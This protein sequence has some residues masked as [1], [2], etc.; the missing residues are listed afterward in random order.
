MKQM[1]V[2]LMVLA[3]LVGCATAPVSSETAAAVPSDRLFNA[4]LTTSAPDKAR[5]VVTR[6][7][8][9]MGSACTIQVFCDGTLA[10]GIR[11]EEKI[12]L[13]LSPGEHIVGV[14]HGGGICGGG[15]DQI[16]LDVA[17]DKPRNL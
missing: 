16:E 4:E 6:D 7:R 2:S 13:Y 1:F 17:L 9:I 5:V 14:K 15:I 11:S 3:S 10:A 12:V 8:G